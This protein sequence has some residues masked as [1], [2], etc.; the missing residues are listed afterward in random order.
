MIGGGEKY[1]LY[2]DHELRR[3]AAEMEMPVKTSIL[4]LDGEAGVV[5][6]D[7]G[8]DCHALPELA[9]LPGCWGFRN[10]TELSGHLQDYLGAALP[11]PSPHGMHAAVTEQYGLLQFGEKIRTVMGVC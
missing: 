1:V 8:I 3:A 6:S 9:G 2:V 5:V 7:H 4:V 11:D 10:A